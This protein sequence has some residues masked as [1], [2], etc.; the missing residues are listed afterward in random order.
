MELKDFPFDAEELTLKFISINNW[1]TLDQTR[2]GNDPVNHV[3]ILRPMLDR[4]DVDF[5]V[6]G[7]GGKI[8]EFNMLRWS[9]DVKNTSNPA[10]PIVFKFNFHLVR[11]ASF[12]V[13]KILFPLWLITISSMV[14]FGIDPQ[15]L[16]GRLEVL[17]TLMLSTIALMYVVQEQ[18]PKISFLTMIDKIVNATLFNLA[19]SVLFSYL[20]STVPDSGRMNMIM[21]VTNQVVYWIAN[22]AFIIPP[23]MRFRKTIKEQSMQT[24]VQKKTA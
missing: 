2:H 1:R 5:F 19:L 4:K 15:D 12:Y 20:V 10:F 21:S 24:M 8:Q 16:Q 6:P 7:W 18:I 14:T 9:Q 13:Y 23:Y 22:I 3:Y 17:F 11:I